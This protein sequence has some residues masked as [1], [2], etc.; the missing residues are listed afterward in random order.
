M[1]SLNEKQSP[2]Q[3]TFNMSAHFNPSK[4][5]EIKKKRTSFKQAINNV[6]TKIANF[7]DHPIT[8]SV[9]GIITIYALLADDIRQL[10]GNKN[11]DLG[12]DIVTYIVFSVFMIEIVLSIWAKPKYL[13]GYLRKFEK[14]Y[15]FIHNTFC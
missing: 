3:S 10:S 6:R 5:K 15:F 14:I 12:F 9:I 11:V 2:T 13:F 8:I 1:Q 4:L 7:V